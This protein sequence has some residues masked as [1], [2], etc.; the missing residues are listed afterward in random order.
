MTVE[1][2]P[3]KTSLGAEDEATRFHTIL[4]SN[5]NPVKLKEVGSYD[6]P[7]GRVVQLQTYDTAPD[8]Q[9]I[10][11]ILSIPQEAL[12]NKIAEVD[13]L[14]MEKATKFGSDIV[15]A[16]ELAESVAV[17]VEHASMEPSPTSPETESDQGKQEILRHLQFILDQR[18]NQIAHHDGTENQMGKLF[19]Q[20][21]DQLGEMDADGLLDPKDIEALASYGRALRGIWSSDRN[22]KPLPDGLALV[23]RMIEALS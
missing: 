7:T 15:S 23:R 10:P 14:D 9:P 6:S 4:D 3:A 16:T 13:H 8:G 1:I 5:G 17:D 11:R 21:A 12:S 2:P 18:A 19:V 20:K 22:A